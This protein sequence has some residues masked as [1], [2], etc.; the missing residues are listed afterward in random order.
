M[1]FP[2]SAPAAH[3]I[4]PVAA[5]AAAHAHA[6]SGHAHAAARPHLLLDG[7]AVVAGLLCLVLLLWWAGQQRARRCPDCGFCP[8][9]CHCEQERSGR[10]RDHRL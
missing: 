1:H 8:I 5:T 9:F 10:D 4:A 6:V 3:V 2:R 7:D